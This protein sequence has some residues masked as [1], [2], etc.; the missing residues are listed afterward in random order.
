MR[1]IDA[2]GLSLIAIGIMMTGAVLL[3]T[4]RGPT[5]EIRDFSIHEIPSA[6]SEPPAYPAPSDQPI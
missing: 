3:Y 1:L 6:P 5:V 2:I 4:A